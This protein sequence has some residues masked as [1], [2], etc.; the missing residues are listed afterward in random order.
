MEPIGKGPPKKGSA[1]WKKNEKII[2]SNP[3]L[4]GLREQSQGATGASTS[5]TGSWVPSEAY[6]NNYD[7]IFGK[8]ED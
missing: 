3:I 6:K 8:K 2:A 7:Q 5:S 4:R 1:A